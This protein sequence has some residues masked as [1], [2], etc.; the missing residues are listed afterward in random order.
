MCGIEQVSLTHAV[1]PTAEVSS[2]NFITMDIFA[3]I[4][5]MQ[6]MASFKS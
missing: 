4:Q 6:C 2:V 3:T 5:V 1:F